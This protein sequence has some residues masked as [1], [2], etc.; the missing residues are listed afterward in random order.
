MTNQEIKNALYTERNNLLVAVASND[1]KNTKNGE[2]QRAG[3]PFPY[4]PVALYQENQSYRNRINT[5]EEQIKSIPNEE[6]SD[7]PLEED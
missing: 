7:I 2:A 1:Y 5:I 6:E 4:D 3:M